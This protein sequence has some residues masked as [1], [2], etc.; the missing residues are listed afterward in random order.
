MN[1]STPTCAFIL[2]VST[3]LL[4][5]GCESTNSRIQSRLASFNTWDA[6][7]QDRLRRG[8]IQDGDNYDMVYIALG[9]ADEIATI[10]VSDGEPLTTWTYTRLSQRDLREETVGYRDESEFDIK[11]GTRVHYQVPERQKVS[12][13]TKERGMTVI[14]RRGVISSVQWGSTPNPTPEPSTTANN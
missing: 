10:P 1:R 8:L 6:A 4:L 11:T 3:V 7:T 2:L 5:T 12:R 9:S 14:F 13:P